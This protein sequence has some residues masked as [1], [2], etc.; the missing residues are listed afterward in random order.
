MTSP[1]T[2]SL[3]VNLTVAGMTCLN[4]SSHVSDAL[5]RVPGV[6]TA[7]VDYRGARAAVELAAGV[8]HTPEVERAL[9]QAVERAGYEALISEPRGSTAA[10]SVSDVGMRT[11]EGSVTVGAG[12]SIGTPSDVTDARSWAPDVRATARAEGSPRHS[13]GEV[14]FDLLILGTGGAGVAAAIHAA[15]M[16]ATCAIVERGT[17][18]GTCVNVGCIPSKALIEAAAHYHVARRGFPGIVPCE[19]VLDWT[20][21]VRAKDALVTELRQA[22]Y[23]DV[24]ASYPG[25]TRLEGT[26]EILESAVGRIRVRVGVTEYTAR[27]VIIATGTNPALPTIRGLDVVEALDSTSAMALVKLPTSLIVLGGGPVGVELGQAFAR[28]GVQVTIVQRG[29][30]LLP[31]E[32]PAITEVLRAE[33]EAE[34]LEV[35]KGTEA[36][37]IERDAGGVV[38]TVHNGRLEGQLRAERVLAATGRRPNIQELGLERVGVAVS[39]RGYVQVDATMR[40]SHPDIYAAGD[41]TGGPAYVYVA[42]AGGRVAAENAIRSI[43]P[44]GTPTESPREAEL[45]VVPRVTFADPQVASVGLTDAAARA[46]GI[47]VDVSVVDMAQ[48]PR[49]LVA[50]NTRGMV[51]LVAEAGSGKILG[52]HAVAP[53]AGELMGEAA[54]A[55]RFG[56]TVRD[57]SGTLHP[58]LTWGESVKLAAQGIGADI[59]KLSCCA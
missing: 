21:V 51:K 50:R 27:K 37:G 44:S 58:Y 55:V 7:R 25:I 42:A 29:P 30:H 56:L 2:G 33:L 45:A 48:V 49:A 20:A 32:D 17:L 57:L 43:S 52:V 36:T 24:L 31:G 19:P 14:A 59:S 8:A 53:N 3:S 46:A 4:C 9:V 1:A 34:G 16:G 15:G 22:K 13:T 35:H 26:A 23:A 18:G 5:E 12:G 11:E 28:F 6:V 47:H 10:D 41:V 54:L 38:V 39:P 40:T